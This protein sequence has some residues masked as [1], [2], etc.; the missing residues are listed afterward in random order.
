MLFGRL[1]AG[2]RLGRLPSFMRR[3]DILCKNTAVHPLPVR[4]KFIGEESSD[5]GQP[6]A[7][8]AC[9]IAGCNCRQGWVQERRT[10]R[11]FRLW[12][13]IHRNGR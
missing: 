10:S 6:M 3:L 9:P 4:M 7:V 2:G 8:Y 5:S 11:P 13:G 12:A 1:V